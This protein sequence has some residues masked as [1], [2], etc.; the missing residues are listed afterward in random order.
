ML[1]YSSFMTLRSQTPKLSSYQLTDIIVTKNLKSISHENAFGQV[2]L[3]GGER[4]T[5][6]TYL[7]TPLTGELYPI[8]TNLYGPNR[9]ETDKRINE[10]DTQLIQWADSSW[11]MVNTRYFE[12]GDWHCDGFCII[13]PF[14]G[15]HHCHK[16][17]EEVHYFYYHAYD[18]NGIVYMTNLVPG[19]G[20]ILQ[21][22][23]IATD[24]VTDVIRNDQ[25]QIIMP[26]FTADY[27]VYAQDGMTDKVIL[28]DRTTLQPVYTAYMQTGLYYENVT[29][30]NDGNVYAIANDYALPG[31]WEIKPGDEHMIASVP[32]GDSYFNFFQ[33]LGVFA[34][35]DGN[36]GFYI[37]GVG[38]CEKR[39][40]NEPLEPQ[41]I[42]RLKDGIFI[43][44]FDRALDSLRVLPLND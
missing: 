29:V 19:Y 22:W 16:S 4:E 21:K 18:G 12:N 5:L 34:F 42:V 40:P 9:T 28:A 30:G 8:N 27:F 41:A 44:A 36:G 35:S 14:T 3:S 23:N 17:T 1:L 39:Y 32:K 38:N 26:Q 11:Y 10:L 25:N 20:M 13:N 33:D 37:C 6:S 43:I 15:E 31:I 24:T 7:L 2:I